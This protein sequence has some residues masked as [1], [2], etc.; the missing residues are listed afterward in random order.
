MRCFR[1]G[2]E[3][4]G[5]EFA[6]FQFQPGLRTVQQQIEDAVARLTG[7][8]VRVDAAGRTD[9][10]VHALGQVVSLRVDTRIPT[11]RLSAALNSALPRD[12][13]AVGAVE[14]DERFHARFSARSRAY[15]YVLLQREHPS[16]LFGRY[17]WHVPGPLDIAAMRSAARSL[18]GTRDFAAWA[19]GVVEARTTV[20]EVTLCRVRRA[21]R[22]VLVRIEANAFLRGM[23]RN[24]VGTLVQVGLGRRP[25]EDVEAITLSRQRSEAGPTAPPQGLCLVR[26]RY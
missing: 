17:A 16:A 11:E 4:D 1:V 21:G 6:G 8:R 2:I 5:T 19:N 3:Y 13:R 7:A 18:P 24:V 9:A 23:V 26:V 10:G 25:P 12:V 20:R 14:A 15:V 22:L